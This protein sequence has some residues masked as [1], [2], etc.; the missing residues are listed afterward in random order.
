MTN[1]RFEE[2]ITTDDGERV[3]FPIL[4]HE[5]HSR[6][7]ALEGV[8]EWASDDEINR[9]AAQLEE[10]LGFDLERPDD[11]DD[12]RLSDDEAAE[13]CPKHA[14]FHPATGEWTAR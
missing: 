4:V 13:Y 2:T 9:A 3:A 6:P 7:H 8:P 5:L 14:G 12:V 11:Y 10:K 1:Y